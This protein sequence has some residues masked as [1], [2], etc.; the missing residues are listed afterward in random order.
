MFVTKKLI[1]WIQI[2]YTWLHLHYKWEKYN[3]VWNIQVNNTKVISSAIS[4]SSAFIFCIICLQSCLFPIL[5]FL[6][7]VDYTH[8]I[9]NGFVAMNCPRIGWE[10]N[11]TFTFEKCVFDFGKHTPNLMC[12]GKWES[13]FYSVNNLLRFWV[14]NVQDRTSNLI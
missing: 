13:I 9:N 8:K 4:S 3:S 14:C 1:T 10:T 12:F 11:G 7:E 5:F 6:V 2:C